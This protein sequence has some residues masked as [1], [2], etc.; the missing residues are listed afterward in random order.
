MNPID[1]ARKFKF[2]AW[3]KITKAMISPDYIDSFGRCFD[4]DPIKGI[5]Q[6][7]DYILMQF[8]GLV[9]GSLSKLTETTEIFEGDIIRNDPCEG[10]PVDGVVIWRDEQAAFVVEWGDDIDFLCGLDLDHYQV[11]GN[12]YEQGLTEKGLWE[13]NNP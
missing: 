10:T 4:Y 7:D 6:D 11:V 5:H 1:T 8:T 12:V 13:R 9:A 2:R 3:S